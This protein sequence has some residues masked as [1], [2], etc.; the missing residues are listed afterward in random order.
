[1]RWS[2]LPHDPTKVAGRMRALNQQSWCYERCGDALVPAAAVE[3]TDDEYPHA[4]LTPVAHQAPCICTWPFK[5]DWNPSVGLVVAVA[6]SAAGHEVDGLS[7]HV[8][9]VTTGED[10]RHPEL[11]RIV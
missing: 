1:M 9:D 7:V 4:R 6:S 2:R 11:S 3:K 8:L 5:G 10:R